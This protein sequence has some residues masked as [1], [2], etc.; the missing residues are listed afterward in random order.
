MSVC[1][2]IKL[3]GYREEKEGKKEKEKRVITKKEKKK[4]WSPKEVYLV[5]KRIIYQE[6]EKLM[7]ELANMLYE[8]SLAYEPVKV[9][10]I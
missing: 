5:P 9:R 10:N 1:E 3:S 6:K 7:T 4:K 2:V 8:L